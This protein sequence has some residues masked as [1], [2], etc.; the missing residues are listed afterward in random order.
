MD[1][2]MDVCTWSVARP[3]AH[4][5]IQ[6]HSIHHIKA[7]FCPGSNFGLAHCFILFCSETLIVIGRMGTK[8]QLAYFL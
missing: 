6:L 8:E 7:V 4:A 5:N 2:V 1:W 3:E